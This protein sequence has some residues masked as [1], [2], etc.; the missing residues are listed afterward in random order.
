MSLM[1]NDV[2]YLFMCLFD[3][4]V[5]S[6]WK[7]FFKCFP[8]LTVL[9]YFNIY[10]YDI[11]INLLLEFFSKRVLSVFGLPFH[12][13][14]NIFWWEIFMYMSANVFIFCF[15]NFSNFILL[16]K[17]LCFELYF[18]IIGKHSEYNFLML[19]LRNCKVVA[20]IYRCMSHS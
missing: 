11:A 4:S 2:V 9:S 5:F 14:N 10:L 6:L 7:Y 16:T 1:N 13:Q 15:V 18:K 19:S 20:V 8:L 17:I 3:I 12:F